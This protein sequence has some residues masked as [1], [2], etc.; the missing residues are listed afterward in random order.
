MKRAGRPALTVVLAG[1]VT[2]EGGRKTLRIASELVA[3]PPGLLTMT[4]KRL[5]LSSATT[6]GVV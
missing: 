2:I 4:E 5:L 6:G 3:L 1:C